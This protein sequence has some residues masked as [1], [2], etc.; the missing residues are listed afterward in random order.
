MLTCS[1]GDIAAGGSPSF[2]V[3]VTVNQDASGTLTNTAEVSSDTTDPNTGDNEAEDNDTT[4][5]TEADLSITKDDGLTE[6]NTG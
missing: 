5:L 1:L 6:I 4:V 3:I 2:D